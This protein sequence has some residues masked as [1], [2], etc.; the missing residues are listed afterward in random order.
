M[1]A[2]NHALTAVRGSFLDISAVCEQPSQIEESLRYHEDG[3]LL[4]KKG[5]I[6]W[7]GDWSAGQEKIPPNCPL[8]HHRDKLIVPGFV[9]THLHF[10]QA[11]IVGAY[12]EQLLQWLE[13]HAFPAEKKFQDTAHTSEMASFFI[14]QLLRNGTTTASAFCSVH[15]RSVTALFE[16]AEQINLRIIAGKVMMD[17][18]APEDLLDSAESS[19]AESK[20]LI[21]KFHNRGR[22][23][24]AITPRFAP[25]STPG[26]LEMAGKLKQ[27]FPDTYIQTHLSENLEEIEWVKELFPEQANYFDVYHHH[28]LTGPRSIFAHCVHLEAQEWDRFHETDSVIS[29]CPTSNLFL[30][31][32]LFDMQKAREKRIRVGMGTDIGAG[33]T[34]NMLKTL[35]EAYKVMQLHRQRFAPSEALYSATLGGA[36]AL[37]LDHLIG[38]FEMGKE[39]DFV[40]LDPQAT[41]LQARQFEK[42]D[43]P[44]EIFFSLM[45]LGDERSISHTYVDGCLVHERSV[46]EKT[47]RRSYE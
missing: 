38:N 26:Q 11:D 29:F 36:R 28:G 2:A 24:Y 18:N 25:T 20:V 34:Y 9:D 27:E 7:F 39:A 41:V 30:G 35:G 5:Q 44:A 45:V 22:L 47:F 19:Y 31:S 37:S 4:L 1:T 23:L 16:A 33:T 8:H 32:G 42:A 21:E 6:E 13:N 14:D 17:R 10:A 43:N 40:V 46:K 15:P 3:L 12:G